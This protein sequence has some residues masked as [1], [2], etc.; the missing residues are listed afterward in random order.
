M[1]T[2][3]TYIGGMNQDLSKLK[4][5]DTVYYEANNIR[6]LTNEGLTSGTIENIKGNKQKFLLSDLTKKIVGWGV[7]RDEIILFT[8]DSSG[9]SFIELI[10]NDGTEI[11]QTTTTIYS[12]EFKTPKLNFSLEYPIHT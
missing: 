2:I 11:T 12:D 9:N 3:N 8:N 4:K 5:R 1:E 10:E 7:I 6:L